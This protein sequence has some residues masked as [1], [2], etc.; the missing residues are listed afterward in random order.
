MNMKQQLL[1]GAYREVKEDDISGPGIDAVK[2]F[3]DE[4]QKMLVEER[5]QNDENLNALKKGMTD[6]VRVEQ[7]K[8]LED[9]IAEGE[10]KL[11]SLVAAVNRSARGSSAG[12]SADDRKTIETFFATKHA[13]A[14][15]PMAHLPAVSDDDVQAYKDYAR[16]WTKFVR[17]G[18]TDLDVMRLS[19]EERKT[20]TVGSD[21]QGGYLVPASMD[22]RVVTRVFDTS[23]MRQYASAIT[24]GSETYEYSLD[25]IRGTSGGWV[26]ELSSRAVTA[27]PTL[28]K[29]LIQ[30]HE[31]YANPDIS[32]KML[33]DGVVNV[34]AWLGDK[35]AEIF[36]HT[37][38]LAFVSG[39]G[40][41]KPRGFLDYAA[42][43]VTTEDASRA[44]GTLQYVATGVSANFAATDPVYSLI[45]LATKPKTKYLGNAQYFM[46]RFTQGAVRKLKD[47]AGHYIWTLGDATRG[48]PSTLLGF[49]VAIL[50][51]LPSIGAN[52][53]SIVF[54]D[55]AQAYLIVD[56]LGI[57]ILRDPYS[58]KPKVQF[59]TRKR[60]GGDVIDFDALK[61]LKFGTS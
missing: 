16:V 13:L 53:F 43:A 57:S 14:G 23:P 8:K 49:P 21:P 24:I 22:G 54:G 60:T 7:M 46:N 15:R 18:G 2:R 38:N 29:G 1:G 12:V 41:V 44:W 55:M 47:T 51:D 37:E 39:N 58:S 11:E 5:K 17:M 31:Q 52:S 32:Q 56:R 20:M 36:A 6:V 4:L 25:L 33:E 61:F 27:T 45:D 26:G 3:Q 30:V 40:I 34:E 28:G 42:A 10:R 50:E 48:V 19:D 59:Y 35:I 9:A